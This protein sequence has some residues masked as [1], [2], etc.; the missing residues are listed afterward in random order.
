MTDEYAF[1]AQIYDKVWGTYD[2]D[3]D[4]KFLDKL[5]KKHHSKKIIDIGC[6]TGNHA[7]RLGAL[8]YQVTAT[9]ASSAM[10]KIAK[11]KI[12][13][14]KT[15]I[16][17]GDMKKLTSIFPREKFDA[18]ISLGHVTYHLN[19]NRE[20]AIFLEGVHKILRKNGLL[21]FNARNAKKI[22][23][24]RLNHLFLDHMISDSD[25]QLVILG[26]NERDPEDANT[27]IWNPIFL[28]KKNKRIDLQI[29]Q[30]KLHWFTFQELKKLLQDRGFRLASVYSGPQKE[31]FNENLHAD[32]WFV[33]TTK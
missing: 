13:N 16:K 25:I 22:D 9:D 17:Q 23:E 33:A 7:T 4:V 12:K 11:S 26:Q 21:I 27:I 3:T 29:R 2:Y 6:G 28:V 32:M 1:E 31:R 18:A 30:H 24:S 14:K 19:T 15:H 20:A 5:F 8:G 10:L